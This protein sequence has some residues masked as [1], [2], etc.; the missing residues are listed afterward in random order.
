MNSTGKTLLGVLLFIVLIG[1]SYLL[2]NNLSRNYKPDDTIE[3][4]TTEVTETATPNPEQTSDTKSQKAP[5]FK[6]YD[7]DGQEVRLSDFL[8]K[9]VVLNFWASW[10][11]PCKSEM[12]DFNEVYKSIEND[13]VIFMMVDLTDGKRETK[14][15]GQKFI[16]EN[17]YEFPVYYDLDQDAAYTYGISS[18][19][20]TIFINAEGNLVT[21]QKGTLKKDMLL[22]GI[23]LIK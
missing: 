4:P 3:S 14:E 6:V 7:Q 11:G 19:P 16:E 2:Y 18:I 12:P 13:E 1:G 17:G 21:Y 22:A 5:D 9:P 20:T 15:D 10:C 8:G 23:N